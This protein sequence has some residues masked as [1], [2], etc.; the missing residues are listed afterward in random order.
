MVERKKAVVIISLSGSRWEDARRAINAVRK[1]FDDPIWTK[2][3]GW[4]WHHT[5]KDEKVQLVPA[6]LHAHLPHTG[7][8]ALYPAA[9]TIDMPR[10]LGASPFP[11][12][13]S[14]A[15]LKTATLDRFEELLEVRLPEDYRNF[16][17]RNNG[18]RPRV[19]GFRI[20]NGQRASDEVLDY[21]LGIAQGEEDDIVAFLQRYSDRLPPDLLPIA[22]DAFGNLI[23]LGLSEPVAGQVLFWDHELEPELEDDELSNVTVIAGNF[24][25]F[26]NSFFEDEDDGQQ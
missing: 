10:R 15:A 5:G 2:P 1:K 17:L 22:Y 24:D 4:I 21:F 7:G 12:T 11:V 8:F 16:L 20:V 6:K 14:Y 18:G 26:L 23:C 3:R 19:N 9:N 13:D 25:L